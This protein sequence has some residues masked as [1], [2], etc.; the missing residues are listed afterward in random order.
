MNEMRPFFTPIFFEVLDYNSD[1][2]LD[3]IKNLQRLSE[4][5]NVSNIGGWQS[6]SYVESSN[7]FLSP[8]LNIIKPRVQE[9]YTKYGI[10]RPAEIGSYWF[11]INKRDNY[12]IAHRHSR[13][14]FSVVFY[15]KTPENCGNI[16]FERPDLLN[17]FNDFDEQSEYN[18]PDWFI[19][20]Q[21]NLLIAFPAFLRHGVE[22]SQSDEERISLAINFV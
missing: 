21:K 5:R 8:L 17:E 6:D 13:S 2:N 9:L 1:N 16:I 12:N 18:Y 3:N 7:D 19:T 15:F 4:G 10:L 14:T 11:N 22:P 20:P